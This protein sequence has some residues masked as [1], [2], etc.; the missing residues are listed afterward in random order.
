MRESGAT[1]DAIENEKKNLN[2]GGWNVTGYLG[3]RGEDL[4][5]EDIRDL[6][7]QLIRDTPEKESN[8]LSFYIIEA[9]IAW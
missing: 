9:Y 3:K 1:E 4:L 6:T 5:R 7:N 2:G 8:K